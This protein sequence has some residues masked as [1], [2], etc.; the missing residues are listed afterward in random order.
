MSGL[1]AP[2]VA[3]LVA[4]MMRT[5]ALPVVD[6]MNASSNVVNTGAAVVPDELAAPNAMLLLPAEVAIGKRHGLVVD[7]SERT[8]ALGAPE[9]HIETHEPRRTRIF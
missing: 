1:P 8:L 6:A 3:A 5:P 7:A 4:L 2:V 9:A